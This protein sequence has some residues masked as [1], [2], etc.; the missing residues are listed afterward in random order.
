MA[1]LVASYLA[2]HIGLAL[3]GLMYVAFTT[4]QTDYGGEYGFLP[5]VDLTVYD[6]GDQFAGTDPGTGASDL[7]ATTRAPGEDDHAGLFQQLRDM[8]GFVSR[9]PGIVLGLFTFNYPLLQSGGGF[10]TWFRVAFQVAGSLAS[11][12]FAVWL[13]RLVAATG[14]LSN[15]WFWIVS[16]V[17][18]GGLSV[19]DVFGIG[20]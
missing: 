6:L 2:L 17:A 10:F 3:A 11:L 13:V 9:L 15:M 8:L 5:S 7:R 4:G 18:F 20:N 19:L 1:Q 12:G 16:G 14:L